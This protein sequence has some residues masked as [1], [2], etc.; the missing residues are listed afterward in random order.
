IGAATSMF[1]VVDHVLLRALKYKDSNRLVTIWS[2]VSALMGDTVAGEIWNRFTLSYEDYEEWVRQQTVFEETGIF[3]T[4][5]AGF[6]GDYDARTIPAARAS[7]NFFA[8]LGTPFLAGRPFAE[9]AE[10]AVDISY[11]FWNTAVGPDP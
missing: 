7:A 3:T 5:N 1:T 6:V 10:D 4:G 2:T 11:E 8:L 9:R